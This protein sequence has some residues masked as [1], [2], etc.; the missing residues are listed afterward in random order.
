LKTKQPK[1]ETNTLV[2]LRIELAKSRNNKVLLIN[3][4]KS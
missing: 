3:L 2:K 4:I 1:E